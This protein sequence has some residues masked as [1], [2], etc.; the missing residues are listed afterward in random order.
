VD[1]RAAEFLIAVYDGVVVACAGTAR[2]QEGAYFYG[3]AV[4][5]SFQRKGIG[6]LLMAAR[7]DSLAGSRSRYAFALVMFW[8]SRFF[9]KFGFGP[10]KRR[11]L[12]ASALTNSDLANAG[13]K[14]SSVMFKA[15]D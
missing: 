11:D 1:L 10:V 13:F 4:R 12:P 14:R 2:N 3:L 15:L 7:L 9:R 6:S 8:N 5:R